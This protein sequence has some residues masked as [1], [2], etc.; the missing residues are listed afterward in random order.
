MRTHAVDKDGSVK[1]AFKDRFGYMVN[2]FIFRGKYNKEIGFS[3]GDL[4][5]PPVPDM[6]AQGDESTV[7]DLDES[8]P[9]YQ[10]FSSGDKVGVMSEERNILFV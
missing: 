2:L 6:Q 4:P 9:F 8:L 7:V 3:A 1:P 10:S 5:P